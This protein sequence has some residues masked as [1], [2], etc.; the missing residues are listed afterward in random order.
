MLSLAMTVIA[1]YYAISRLHVWRQESQ[2]IQRGQQVQAEVVGANP[3]A[4]APPG[5]IYSPDVAV[6]LKY[7]WNGQ[8]YRVHGVLGGRTEQIV[9]RKKIPIVIDPADPAR[10]TARTQPGSLTQEMLSA[11]MLVPFA[12]VL[13]AMALWR[14]WQVLS[15]YRDG[16]GVLAEV[17]GVSHSAAAP[18]SRLLRCAVHVGDDARVIK[19]LLPARIAPSVGQGVWLIAPPGRAEAAIP[20]GLFE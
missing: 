2:L 3:E 4:D 9:S 1:A 20:A 10:W 7:T 17:V 5:Q 8:S 12:V 18:L 11:M 15:I 6:D 19:I 13:F 16:E 14:R